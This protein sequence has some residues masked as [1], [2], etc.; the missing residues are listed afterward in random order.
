MLASKARGKN[1]MPAALDSIDIHGTH[2]YV[3]R[4]Y[5]WKEW[6][7]LRREAPVYW[8]EREDIE[9]FWAITRHADV[10]AISR[11]PSTFINGGRRL[12]LASIG[13]E[14]LMTEGFK[15]FAKEQGWDPG[16]PPDM[17]FMDD[18]RHR[19]FRLLTSSA[20]TPG[21]LRALEPRIEKLATGFAAEFAETLGRRTAEAGSC[22]FVREYSV[23]LPLAAIGD[24]MGLPPGDWMRALVWTNAMLGDIHPSSQ[25]EGE[26]PGGA[27]RRAVLEMR[28]YFDALMEERRD[29]GAG[30]EC[31]VDMLLRARLDGEP[32]TDQQLHGYLL[33]LTA[34]G[35]ET[36][37]NA[38]TGGLIALLE[39]PDQRDLLCERPE[40]V[41]S[42]VE[43]ILR[44]TS[45]VVQFARTVTKDVEI[46]G[47]KIREG[48][49]V[50]VFYPSANRDE[51]VFED[52]DRFDVTRQPNHHLAFGH[53]SHFCLG[54]NLARVELR[55]AI[56]ALLPI[57]PRM[58][59][60]DA[61]VRIPHLHVPGFR[62]LAVR[63]TSA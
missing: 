45:P 52:P 18:P 12:R 31:L 10:L 2:L 58:E 22:D 55:A 16:E 28:A 6:E 7:L 17:V 32:L 50:G 9:P 59:L 56:R 5:P 23:K 37:R 54:A 20:F 33:L 41:N 15:G 57:L 40:L 38:T 29:A 51:D 24:L 46:R 39:N 3:E 27:A 14:I 47:Q 62:S 25:V 26:S 43:E 60:V 44:W 13:E 63:Y 61:G 8:Y 49:T 11:D 4:G 30:S 53:G 42:A 35:N 36:T 1:A 48:D 34:A 21:R 19:K